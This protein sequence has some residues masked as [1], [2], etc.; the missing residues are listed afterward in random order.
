MATKDKDREDP[1]KAE[2]TAVQLYDYGEHA[3]VGFEN[4]TAEDYSIPFLNL[5]QALSPE[6]QEGGEKAVP[7]ARPGMFMNSVTRE[8]IDG[9]K[10]LI[11]VPCETQHVYV[12][13][14]PRDAGGGM[15]GIHSTT[16]DVVKEAK[17]GQASF[18][19]LKCKAVEGKLP[20]DLIET[21]Y[22]FC[23]VLE[24]VGSTKVKDTILLAFTSTK[25]KRYKSIMTRLRT[26]NAKTPLFAHRLKCVSVTDKNRKGQP[27]FNFEVT[28]AL[29]DVIDS[30]INPMID[31][32]PNPILVTGDSFVKSIRG[33]IGKVAYETATEDATADDEKS[34]KVF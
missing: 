11:L 14:I 30:L 5:L 34:D 29:G 6:V 24:D 31:G 13:W 12:E 4:T 1:K 22:M 25:I 8:L 17:A 32:Q 18:G 28:P 3:G 9:K 23:L 21:F 20:N 15:V 16:S 2:S 33:G 27:F 10:G 19:K 26:F 7:N